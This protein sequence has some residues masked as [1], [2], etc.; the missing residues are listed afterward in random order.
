MDISELVTKEEGSV[1]TAWRWWHFPSAQIQSS[2]LIIVGDGGVL[3]EQITVCGNLV[4]C[5]P[6]GLTL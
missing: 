6:N 2:G 5:L 3:A 1:L 4:A